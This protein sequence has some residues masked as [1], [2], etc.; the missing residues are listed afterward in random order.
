MG[1]C[2]SFLIAAAAL[3][4]P[5]E[6]VNL[7]RGVESD[8]RRQGLHGYEMKKRKQQRASKTTEKA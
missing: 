7:P 3:K 1:V 8:D 5:R 4:H 6:M 2:R